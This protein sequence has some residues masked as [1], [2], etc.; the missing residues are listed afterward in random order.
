M[1]SANDKY[2]RVLLI[3]CL[4]AVKQ[5]TYYTTWQVQLLCVFWIIVE[6]YLSVQPSIIRVF[7]QVHCHIAVIPGESNF[8]NSWPHPMIDK[9]RESGGYNKY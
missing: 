7:L 5:I 2:Y 8:S 3:I 4:Q 9:Y 1:A 6:L